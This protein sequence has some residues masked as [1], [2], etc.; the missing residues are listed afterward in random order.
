MTFKKGGVPWNKGKKHT[1]E[2][3][4]EM[5]ESKKKWFADGGVSARK[6]K[7]HTPLL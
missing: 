5:S 3:K 1:E 6:G 4:R 7:K 2:I